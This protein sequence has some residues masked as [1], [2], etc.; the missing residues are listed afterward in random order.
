[1][2][3]PTYSTDFHTSNDARSVQVSCAENISQNEFLLFAFEYPPVSGGISRLCA[4]IGGN[5][6]RESAHAF[7]LTQDCTIP[8]PRPVLSEVRV[9]SRRPLREWWALRWLQKFKRKVAIGKCTT[10]CGLWYPEGLIAYLAGIRPL[11]ILAHGSELLPVASLWRRSLWSALQ[12]HVL[13]SATLVIANSEYTR[14]LVLQSAPNAV[15]EAIPLAVDAQRF[16]RGDR[17]AAK[18]KFGLSGKTVLCTVARIHY[19]KGHDVVLRAIASLAAEERE[20]IV[21]LIAGQGPHEPELQN[22]ADTLGVSHQIRWLGFIAE[23]ELPE[24]YH[25]SDLF[26]LCTRDVPGERSVEGFGMAFL[27]AQASGIPVVGTKTGGIPAAVKDGEGGWLIEQDDNEKLTEILRLLL[28]AP[29]SFRNAGEQ[30]RQRVLRTCT[31]H[32]YGQRFALALQ[33][34]GIPSRETK[35][36]CKP[37]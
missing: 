25:A 28:R 21:Y 13:E 27:E 7:V 24:I 2:L 37:A 18:E 8:A 3:N 20:Q 10:V 23:S 32:S 11:V 31:W 9:D 19:Y 17:E 16:T 29:E 15:V 5:M 14:D 33:K 6:H 35:A 36:T 12:R 34:A 4:E 30:A 26:V 22:L 1:M